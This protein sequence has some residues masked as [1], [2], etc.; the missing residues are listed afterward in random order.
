MTQWMQPALQASLSRPQ[1]AGLK[2]Y[3]Q[4]HWLALAA[5]E[6]TAI[7]DQF[8][9]AFHE[10]EA[11]ASP[12]GHAMDYIHIIMEIEKTGMIAEC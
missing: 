4:L 3:F 5:A 1:E 10:A 7:V 12:D 6:I 11:A 8:Y 9:G 2:L